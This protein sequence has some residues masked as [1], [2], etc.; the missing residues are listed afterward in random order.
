VRASIADMLAELGYQVIE[1]QSAEEA[2]RH[3]NTGLRAD[4]VVTDHLMPGMTGIDL[5]RAVQAKAPATPVLI[6]SGYAEMEGID[7]G[8]P[9][10]TKP[11]VNSELARALAAIC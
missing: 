8:L 6:I 7:P 3:V 1:A 9:R 4:V 5:A 11:F 10:L 2:F